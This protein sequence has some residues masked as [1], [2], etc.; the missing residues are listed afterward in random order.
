[1]PIGA[2]AQ[3]DGEV[4]TISAVVIRP[5]GADGVR[6]RWQGPAEAGEAGARELAEWMLARGADKILR[7]IAG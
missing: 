7:E 6:D 2:Y 5:D 3:V 1:M 4:M